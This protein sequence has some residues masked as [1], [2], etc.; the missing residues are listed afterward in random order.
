MAQADL[1]CY[2]AKHNGRGQFS[3]Y[4]AKLID[5]LK[6]VLSQRENEQILPQQLSSQGNNSSPLR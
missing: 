1:A 4:E 3:I 5:T 6:P 2:N